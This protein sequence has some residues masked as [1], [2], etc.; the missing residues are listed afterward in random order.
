[1][2][3][4]RLHAAHVYWCGKSVPSGSHIYKEPNKLP[5]LKFPI[6]PRAE[7]NKRA[8]VHELIR[9]EY[10]VYISTKLYLIANYCSLKCCQKGGQNPPPSLSKILRNFTA[11][12]PP[13][14][15]SFLIRFPEKKSFA[16]I[17]PTS[18]WICQDYLSIQDHYRSQYQD[19]YHI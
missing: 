14:F 18:I 7:I 3:T 9:M 10:C 16:P 8:Y 19:R 12:P 15:L 1:M 13:L 4:F 2:L 11:T 17:P 6:K 5:N